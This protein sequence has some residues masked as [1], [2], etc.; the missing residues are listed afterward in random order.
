M[1]AA[2][3]PRKVR[4]LVIGSSLDRGAVEAG[5]HDSAWGLV[6]VQA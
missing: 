2:E 5:I 3:T 1:A 6:V 4:V